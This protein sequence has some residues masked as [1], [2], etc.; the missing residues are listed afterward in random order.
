MSKGRDIEYMKTGYSR[1][2][3]DHFFDKL[4]HISLPKEIEN[5]FL[6]QFYLEKQLEMVNFV[7]DAAK[8]DYANYE[9]NLVKAMKKI[10]GV[11][12]E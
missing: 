10:E 5:P 8:D 1:T 12:A 7:V 3:V 6:R 11:S 9:D 4:I 2:V